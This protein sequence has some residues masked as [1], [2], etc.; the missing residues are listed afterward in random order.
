[1]EEKALN[2]GANRF[3][4]VYPWYSGFTGDLLFYIAVDTLFLT[5]VKNFSPAEIVSIT[6]L[7]QLICITLQFPVLFVI[8]KIGNTAS[9]R[10]G[11]FFLL[12]SSVFITLGR[13]YY[14]VLLGR[15]FHDVAAIFRSASVVALENNLELVDRR[16]DFVKLRTSAST[17]YAV[18]TMLIS[19]VASFMFNLNYYLPMIGCITTCATGFVLSIFMKDYSD[20]NKITRKKSSGERV[21]IHC[22]KVIIISLILF[23]VFYS[24]VGNGQSEGKLFIQQNILLDFNVEETSLIIGAIICVSRIIRVMSNLVFVKAYERYQTKM[25]VI[26]PI[27]I[28]CS[29]GF[30]LFGSFIPQIIIKILVMGLG[31][32]IILFIRDPF[33]LF[34]QDVLFD[35]TPKEQHQTLIT[36]MEFGVKIATAGMGLAFSAILLSYPMTVVI[37]IMFAMTV[38]EILLSFVLYRAIMAGKKRSIGEKVS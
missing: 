20:Y 31:Y 1:M 5:I 28:S 29:I 17:V 15:I 26:L 23:S 35:C 12:M 32:T 10:T 38:A 8:K 13:S 11:A 30:M 22:N 4:K 37:S 36:F 19:F 33:R 24:L 7:S 18:I 2:K 34:I 9:V 16:G 6:S 14:V 27:L 25:G 21:K 3:L